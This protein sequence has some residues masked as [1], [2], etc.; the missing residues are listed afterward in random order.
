VVDHSLI[1]TPRNEP[2]HVLDFDYIA[3][4]RGSFSNKCLPD[5]VIVWQSGQLF[6]SLVKMDAPLIQY[7]CREAALFPEK[8]KQQVSGA[9]LRIGNLIRVFRRKRKHAFAFATERKISGPR[10]FS[11]AGLL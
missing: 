6:L 3:R 8:G 4:E 2:Y 7:L 11:P 10:A 1:P 9:D 5:R